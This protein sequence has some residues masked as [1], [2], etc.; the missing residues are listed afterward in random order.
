MS[1]DASRTEAV[2]AGLFHEQ[3]EGDTH[4]KHVSADEIAPDHLAQQA[5]SD[6]VV[7]EQISGRGLLL[8]AAVALVVLIVVVAVAVAIS[9]T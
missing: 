2:Q 9:N 5:N 1:Q 7:G 3:T 6:V 4:H 8:V